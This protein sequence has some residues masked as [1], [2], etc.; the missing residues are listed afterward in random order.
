MPQET[1]LFTTITSLNQRPKRRKRL[2]AAGK[3]WWRSEREL[4]YQRT[5]HLPPDDIFLATGRRKWEEKVASKLGLEVVEVFIH[6]PSRSFLSSRSS[7]FSIFLV[8]DLLDE[9]NAGWRWLISL[10]FHLPSPTV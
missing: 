4:M 10:S 2:S 9:E 8:H 1:A 7:F 5:S 3:D 6:R